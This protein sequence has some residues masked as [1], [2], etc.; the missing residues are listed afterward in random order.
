[1]ATR[2]ERCLLADIGATNARFALLTRTALGPVQSFLV[3]EYPRFLDA[4]NAFLA[5]HHDGAPLSGALLAVAGPVDQNRCAM[6]N[7]DWVI[8]GAEIM[9]N[10]GVAVVRVVNDF[11]ATAS[12]LLHLRPSDVRELGGGKA[13][14][15]TPMAV[16]GPGTGLGVACAAPTEG[17]GIVIASEGGHTTLP[18]VSP[19]EDA[20]INCLRE[21]FG[22][23]SAERT[24][25][26]QGLENLYAA[27]ATIDAIAAPPRNAPE[28]T[29]AALD[30]S[31]PLSVAALDMFCAM[32]GTVA[33]DVALMFGARG[34]VFI[35]GGIAPRIVDFIARSDFRAR[36]EAKGRFRHYLEAVPSSVI[37]HPEATFIG[38][39][40]IAERERQR[41]IP[42]RA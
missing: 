39:K 22:H 1:L 5:D 14:A 19:R 23:V 26:G 8:D 2:F 21:R 40:A 32:L 16:I 17:G 9:D 30:G 3:A 15:G 27:I 13:V 34:G 11:E 24:I 7:S 18:G 10:L 6:T 28:I 38:L 20:I 4:A 42:A 31:C 33:G 37:V 29:Q 12:A 36:F 35:A 25:S 41:I